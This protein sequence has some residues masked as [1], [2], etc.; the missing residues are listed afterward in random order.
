MWNTILTGNVWQGEIIN[1][2]KD[3]SEYCEEM[4][5]TPVRDK[6]G[7]IQNFVAVKQ[8]ISQRKQTE[9]ALSRERELLGTL[10]DNIPDCIY[11]KDRQSR[12]VRFSKAF[13]KLFKVADADSLRGKTDFD[14]FLEEHARPA[15]EDEQQIIRSGKPIIGKLEKENHSDGRV[16]WAI[17][18]KMPWRDKN[19]EIIGTFGIS[20]DV[21][22]IKEAEQS[23]Q[24]MEMQLRQAQKLEAI[25]QL[26]AGIAH[27]IN[28][29]TQY[30]GDNTRF[31]KDSFRSIRPRCCNA[32]TSCS[33]PR[34]PTP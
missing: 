32:T 28:T 16:T 4:T 19:G 31:L 11:F 22:T 8:D 30:V 7:A 2:R 13:A 12:F 10:L 26:A 5:I 1:R 14:F 21:T 17:T 9:Q 15:Y 25:G 18:T 29:P 24:M 20:K 33:V 34:R 3:G 6:E 27:E 23:Q